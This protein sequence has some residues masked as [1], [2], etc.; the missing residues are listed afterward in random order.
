MKYEQ[1]IEIFGEMSIQLIVAL[2]MQSENM[3]RQ[4]LG[5]SMAYGDE[6]FGVVV[7]MI[8]KLIERIKNDLP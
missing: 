2:S 8:E 5:Q 7:G 1:A 4:N 3:Q 6:Q